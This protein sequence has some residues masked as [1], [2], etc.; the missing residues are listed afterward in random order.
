MKTLERPAPTGVR[1]HLTEVRGTEPAYQAY[2]LMYVGY[3]VLPIIAG[4]DKFTHYL[5]DWNQYLTPFAARLLGGQVDLFMRGI[6]LV[7]IAAGILVAVKPRWGALVVGLWLMGII[8]NLLLI[9]GYFDVALRDFGLALGA[10]SFWRLSDQF[11]G[12]T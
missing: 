1:P 7:E 8:G 4:A 9:P 2:S 10:F 5:V 11:S 6:G 12:R 3:T